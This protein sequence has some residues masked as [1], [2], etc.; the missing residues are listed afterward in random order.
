MNN[1]YYTVDQ[2]AAFLHMHVKTVRRYIREGKLPAAK[3]GKQWRING[4]DLST[5][6]EGEQPTVKIPDTPLLSVDQGQAS[7]PRVQVSTVVEVIYETQAEVDR[8][9]NTLTA[10]MQN[11]DPIYGYSTMN[12]QV[13]PSQ[14]KIRVLLW[15][16]ILFI[17]SMLG[18]IRSMVEE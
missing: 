2:V 7:T 1:S 12:I 18:C 6:M 11:K 3:V 15:G 10:V 17:E 14:Q 16:T 9:T 13:L 5:F 4:H 8:I